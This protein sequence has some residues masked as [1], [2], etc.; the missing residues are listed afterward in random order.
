MAIFIN[1]SEA[2]VQ[3]LLQILA[4]LTRPYYF[5]LNFPHYTKVYGIQADLETFTLKSGMEDC[6]RQRRRGDSLPFI[7]LRRNQ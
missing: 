4:S 1:H 5:F 2:N 3:F 6:S 7:T